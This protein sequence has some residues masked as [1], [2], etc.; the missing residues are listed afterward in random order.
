MTSFNCSSSTSATQPQP[1]TQSPTKKKKKTAQKIFQDKNFQQPVKATAEPTGSLLN[2]HLQR[3]Y[4][5]L[6]YTLLVHHIFTAI[7]Q[8]VTNKKQQDGIY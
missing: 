1:T 8:R 2:L 4:R 5:T 6:L 7:L 3:L